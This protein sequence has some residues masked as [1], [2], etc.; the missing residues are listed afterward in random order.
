MYDKIALA[1]PF[2]EIGPKCYL[3]GEQLLALVRAADK[4]SR[5]YGVPVIFD[6]PCA[7]IH[8][9]AAIADDL[10]VFAQHIDAIEPGRGMGAVTAEDV[11]AAGAV[12]VIL[13]HAEKPVSLAALAHTIRRADRVGLATMVCADS[14][15]E[16]AAVAHLGP[17]IVV[18]EPTELIG[19]GKTS[20][21]EYVRRSI[22][23]VKAVDDR[24]LVLQGAGISC[25]Q[26]VY[27]VIKAG[28]DGTGSSSGIV[29]AQDPAAM[30]DEMLCAVRTAWDENH[31]S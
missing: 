28:A 19:S 8:Q 9:V 29:K 14:I 31:A 22:E 16:A 3:Y 6:P 21:A 17:N 27:E 18:A 25:G 13:N 11:K 7:S 4:A 10:L 24:I 20:S 26:D 30:I 23:A 1:A 15:A 12:G 2:F 5:K